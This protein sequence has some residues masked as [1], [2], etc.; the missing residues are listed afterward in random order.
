M[1]KTYRLALVLAI[2]AVFLGSCSQKDDSSSGGSSPDIIKA[3]LEESFSVPDKSDFLTRAQSTNPDVVGWLSV[4]GS[5]IEEPVLQAADNEYYLHKDLAKEYSFEGSIYMDFRNSVQNFDF[6][7]IIY[8]HNLGSPMGVLD[9]PDGTKFAPLLKFADLEFAKNNP[10][11]LL[12]TPGKTSVYEI[13]AAFYSEAYSRP[14]EYF[15]NNYTQIE[16]DTLTRDILKRS[17]HVY[18]TVPGYSDKLITLS[19]CTYKY[20]PYNINPYQRF[21]VVGRLVTDTNNLPPTVELYANPSPKQ[22]IFE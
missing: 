6:N 3:R 12:Y 8:G 4:P 22:P 5:G 2:F 11:I 1:K 16:F 14:V 21:V 10:Y 7:T 15:H 9:Y 19:T 18:P 17:E 20:G 13:Y